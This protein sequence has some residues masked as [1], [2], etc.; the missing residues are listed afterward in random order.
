MSRTPATAAG[1]RGSRS[2]KAVAR[3][4]CPVAGTL[5][6][7][8]D[9]WTLLVLRDLLTGKTRYGQFLASPEGIS[10][11]LLADRL[12]RMEAA[13]LVTAIPYSE[14]PVRMDYR[15]TPAGRALRPVVDALASW[16]LAHLPGTSPQL[17]FEPTGD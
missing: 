14:H 16:G 13:G 15:L 3:S 6:L 5:D 1:G 9:R 4:P 17:A 12:Q 8:G 10:T 7:V 11:N 2:G